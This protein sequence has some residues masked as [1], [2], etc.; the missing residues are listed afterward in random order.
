MGLSPFT[1]Q[2]FE[3]LEATKGMVSTA[4]NLVRVGREFGEELARWAFEQWRLRERAKA[5]FARAEEMLFDRD[6][7]E[8]ASSEPLAELHV[9]RYPQGIRMAD[10]TVGIGAD[11][12]AIARN[13]PAIGYEIDPTRAAMAQ[14]NLA[15]HGLE[16]EIR[17]QNCK[18]GDWDFDYAF[19]DPSRRVQGKR[20]PDPTEFS[21][22]PDELIKKMWDLTLGGIKL[23]PML[24]D[25]FLESLGGERWFLSHRREC[26]EV[27][28]L[29]GKEH[30]F[31]DGSRSRGSWAAKTGFGPPL[32]GGSDS[33]DTVESPFEF[34]FE[35]DPAPIRAHALGDLCSQLAAVPV[36]ES[37]GY[38]T[39]HFF[40][41][42][43]LAAS[44]V[45]AYRVT[46][47]GHADEKRL[48]K[49]LRELESGIAAVKTR[50]VREDP[51]VWMKK[52]ENDFPKKLTL[53]LYPIGKSVRYSLLQA[54][55]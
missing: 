22:R 41:A 52:L 55:P 25:A 48:R 47:S 18:E 39:A 12:I 42:E 29:I 16:A 40:N 45:R 33:P 43:S 11:L 53:A 50:G 27:M 37:N 54:L 10:L 30:Q 28:I 32:V 9:Q 13:G 4:S 15:V 34:L 14:H 17:I 19:A 31:S 1:A 2:H 35:A 6:G 5:K 36:G 21:P 51:A 20:T 23:S 46:T 7:L 38:L 8:M 24:P 44:W 3:A 49:A 26:R